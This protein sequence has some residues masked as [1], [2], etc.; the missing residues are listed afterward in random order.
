MA[1]RRTRGGATSAA[2]ALVL[3]AALALSACAGGPI[4]DAGTYRLSAADRGRVQFRML[5]AVNA[6]RSARAAPALALDPSLTAAA[7]THARD[8]AAQNRP[9]HFG[10]DGSSPPERTA[11]AGYRGAFRGEAISESFESE[12]ETLAAWMDDPGSRDVILDPVA[13]EMGLAWHQERSGKLW[14]ALVMGDP[15]AAPA[16]PVPSAAGLPP[17]TIAPGASEPLYG[18]PGAASGIAP[19]D[20]YPGSTP[21]GAYPEVPPAGAFPTAPLGGAASPYDVP[22]VA[23]P[24]PVPPGL[25]G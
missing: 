14:W 3:G 17:E 4:G 19:A 10:S 25:R 16:V 22:P 18:E 5:D 23:P 7:A 11:R 20:A 24:G 6:L 15:G 8:M 2:R 13:Q 1:E 12:L 21:V 9:W